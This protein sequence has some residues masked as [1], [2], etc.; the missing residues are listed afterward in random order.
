MHRPTPGTGFGSHEPRV[1]PLTLS[2]AD[3]VQ[4]RKWLAAAL[5]EHASVA[6]FSKFALELLAVGAPASLLQ[7]AHQAA[8][9]EIRHAQL[10]FDVVSLT[11]LSDFEFFITNF[12]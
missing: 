3:S 5:A 4:A 6:S 11:N 2:D 10:S 9:D 8:L 1:S 7:R 12:F